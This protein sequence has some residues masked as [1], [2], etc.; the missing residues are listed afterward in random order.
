VTTLDI[1]V[2]QVLIESRIVIVNDDFSR[3]LGVRARLRTCIER[4]QR[5]PRRC[6][7]GS[8]AAQ[9]NDSIGR[10]R[11]RES[12][13]GGGG[14]PF[15]VQIPTCGELPGPLQ[16]QP[17]GQRTRPAASRSS[18]LTST[19]TSIDLELSAAQAEGKRRDRQS[20]PRVI[21][22]NQKRSGDR[23]GRGDSVPGVGVE[24]RR[25]DHAVQEGRAVAEGEAADNART[26]A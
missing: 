17:A 9:A 14:T 3:D 15:P 8:A 16:R 20:A 10:L 24:L 12:R 21:T 2:R 6:L 4:R 18:V 13:Q 1:P 23:A 25:D 22:A 7:I 11:D 26:T 19:T 5:R